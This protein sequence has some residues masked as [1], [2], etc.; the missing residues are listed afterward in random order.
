MPVMTFSCSG[1]GHAPTATEST[2]LVF[3]R[4]RAAS[5]GYAQSDWS[6][7]PRYTICAIPFAGSV[8]GTCGTYPQVR[9]AGHIAGLSSTYLR[10]C[11]I[12]P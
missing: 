3:V 5:S 11:S 2:L 7:G 4:Y 6:R 10:H 9:P 1:T 12:S 8:P